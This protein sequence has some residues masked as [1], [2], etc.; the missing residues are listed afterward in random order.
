MESACLL[1]ILLIILKYLELSPVNN[2]M[3]ETEK[4][5]ICNIFLRNKSLAKEPMKCHTEQDAARKQSLIEGRKFPNKAYLDNT[6][7]CI[8]TQDRYTDIL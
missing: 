7:L 3:Q 4:K 2:E 6:P 5:K 1:I 8:Y